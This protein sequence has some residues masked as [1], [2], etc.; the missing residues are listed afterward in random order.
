MIGIMK[1]DSKCID[2]MLEVVESAHYLNIKTG[3]VRL[4]T[5]KEECLNSYLIF[6]EEHKKMVESKN[7]LKLTWE[8]ISD[9][10]LKLWVYLKH[11]DLE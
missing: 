8:I 11:K 4:F 3:S 7:Y 10:N 5:I 1:L 2:Q 9:P 6:L